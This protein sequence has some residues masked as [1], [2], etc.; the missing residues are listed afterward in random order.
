MKNRLISVANI[1]GYVSGEM[2]MLNAEDVARGWGF[3]TVAKSG[4]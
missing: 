4:N 2:V 1:R 3:T